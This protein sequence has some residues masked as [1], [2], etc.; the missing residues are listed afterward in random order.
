MFWVTFVHFLDTEGDKG[1]DHK[2]DKSSKQTN[3]EL[4]ALC[5]GPTKKYNGTSDN[6]T[7]TIVNHTGVLSNEVQWRAGTGQERTKVS[8]KPGNIVSDAEE[9]G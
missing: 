2:I 9:V 7:C 4:K 8:L 3:S 5:A 6:V 1:K